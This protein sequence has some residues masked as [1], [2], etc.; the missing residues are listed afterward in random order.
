M[1]SQTG[2]DMLAAAAGRLRADFDSIRMLPHKGERGRET[3][4]ALIEFLQRHLPKRFTA[5]SGYVIDRDGTVSRHM[6][7]IVYDQLDA[8]GNACSCVACVHSHCC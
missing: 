8:R 6:D 2:A 3:Q 1:S 4:D 7:V 5:Q